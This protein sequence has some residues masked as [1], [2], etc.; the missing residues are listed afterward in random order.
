MIERAISPYLMELAGKYPVVT[1]TGPRQ[2]GKTTLVRH[3]FSGMPYVNLENPEEREFAASDSL[4]FL[5]RYPEG[6]VLD[7]IQRVPTLLSYLQ[8]IVDDR[9]RNS[10]FILTGSAQFELMSGI[11]QSLAG[12][13][14]LLRLLPFSLP[15]LRKAAAFPNGTDDMIFKGFYP[16]VHDRNLNPTQAYGDYIETYVERDLRRLVAVKNLGLFRKFVKLCAGRTGQ[17]LNLSS[18]GNDA[19][20]S[21][22]T[23]REWLTLLETSYVVFL[24]EPFHR[25]IGKRLIKSPKIYF[26]DVGLAAYLLGIETIGHV[27]RHPLRGSLFENLVLLEF[28]K[29]HFNRGLR[30]RLSFYR[31]RAGHEID[32]IQEI[33]DGMLAVEIKSGETLNSDF[34]KAF[35][36]FAGS[37][38]GQKVRNALVYG[39]EKRLVRDGIRT[40]GVCGVES[41]LDELRSL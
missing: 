1:I 26:Y 19:G 13:T 7:E 17:L 35:D 36:A 37:L 18:L 29:Y 22:T 4:G 15:E 40:T 12:R 25:N 30:P 6:A 8:T 14:A 39:G 24:L 20:V 31:D 5:R 16:P 33:A 11:T 28:L 9:G 21:H 27:E 32:L 41:L 34:F 3:L 2:S 10:K 38:K 23:A